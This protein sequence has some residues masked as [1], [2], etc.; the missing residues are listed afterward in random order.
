MALKRI[1]P[2][3]F[4]G[5][6][7]IGLASCGKNT[8]QG[9]DDTNVLPREKTLYLVGFQWGSPS[10]FNPLNDWPSWPVRPEFN[11]MY[12][13]L[14][15]YN[16]FT[17]EVEPVLGELFEQ[18]QE[19]VSVLINPAAKWSDGVPL[20]AEDVKFSYEIGKKFLSL[21][22]AYVDGFVGD[23]VIDTITT[24]TATDENGGKTTEVLAKGDTL[25]VKDSVVGAEAQVRE[26][27]T[28]YVDKER[29]NNPLALIDLLSSI[30]IYPKHIF[31]PLI[32]QNNGDIAAVQE[33]LMNKAEDHVVSGPYNLYAY[34]IEKIVIKRRDNYWGNDALYGGK[35]PGPE[36]IVH[37]IY[38]GNSHAS[39]ALKH[40]K[41][42]LSANFMPRIWLKKSRGV[43]T[44]FD[45]APYYVPGSIPLFIPNTTK[46]PL[47]DKR[48]RRAMAQAINYNKVGKLAVSGYTPELNSGLI[49]PFSSEEKEY[50]DQDDVD[51]YGA[52]S[53]NIP[54]A[55]R[56][57][58]EAGYKSVR[59]KKGELLAT[60]GPDGDTLPTMFI[61]CPS[62]WSDFESIIK[63][64]ITTMRIAGIDVREGFV[65]ETKYWPARET[66]DF[67]I[68]MDTPSAKLSKSMPWSR[69]ETVMSS[70]KWRPI[71]DKMKENIGR[72]NGPDS[73]NYIPAVD[74]LL[75]AIPLMQDEAEL[76][77]AYKTLNRIFME[78]QPALPVVY[79]PEEFY[80]FSNTVWEGFATAENPYAPPHVLTA[81][82][83]RRMLWNI[84]PKTSNEVK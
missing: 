31:E 49:L 55:K 33:L 77:S 71:G 78:E 36:Y 72:W 6:M 82:A 80:Q 23:V 43:N 53:F 56:I 66:G 52:T 40:G 34:T 54:E 59:D 67:D 51:Q 58:A 76:A 70:A 73:P 57:L 64:S 8:Q 12:E 29:R 74:S 81:G 65:D 16:S 61:M 48:Y 21:P 38:K 13:Q 17:G 60:I 15:N 68:I 1:V 45:G 3:L 41:L 35:Q 46:K 63:L 79:R 10:S 44:W 75:K 27:V 83:S 24:V 30:P 18:N 37:P 62:G 5:L 19:F 50:Y 28:L 4:L 47:N 42:D 69:F 26:R 39:S 32:E 2:L 84:Q 20:T 25:I 7:L 22:T 11:L 14:C 9:T